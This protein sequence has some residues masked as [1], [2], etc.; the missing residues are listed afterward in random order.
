MKHALILLIVLLAVYFVYNL[1]PSKERNA[2]LRVI[3]I[4]GMFVLA[5]ILLVFIT[6]ALAVYF[7]ASSIL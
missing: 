3:T 6:V 2:A 4:H 1:T 7:P 5:I